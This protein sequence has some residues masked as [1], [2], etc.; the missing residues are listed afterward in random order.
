MI[1]MFKKGYLFIIFLGHYHPFA[2][3]SEMKK[4]L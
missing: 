2:N 4:E 3:V 1:S